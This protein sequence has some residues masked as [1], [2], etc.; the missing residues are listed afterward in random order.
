MTN[1]ALSL[2]SHSTPFT[3]VSQCHFVS[4]D[5]PEFYFNLHPPFDSGRS[6]SSST[7]SFSAVLV[8]DPGPRPA[9]FICLF[10]VWMSSSKN[11]RYVWS[12]ERVRENNWLNKRMTACRPSA[13][14]QNPVSK[15]KTTKTSKSASTALEMVISSVSEAPPFPL[16]AM[17]VVV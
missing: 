14:R 17:V 12:T 13:V 10:L 2:Q 16:S 5:F 15:Q 8:G 1:P 7:F 3:S 11:A 9:P 6:L 4:K